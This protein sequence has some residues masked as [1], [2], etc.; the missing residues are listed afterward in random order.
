MEQNQLNIPKVNPTPKPTQIPTV[1]D[2]SISIQTPNK[3]PDEKK[4][5]FLN[6][7]SGQFKDKIRSTEVFSPSYRP[8]VKSIFIEALYSLL[9]SHHIPILMKHG[10]FMDE[11]PLISF[12][13]ITEFFLSY[14][15]KIIFFITIYFTLHYFFMPMVRKIDFPK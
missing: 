13:S 8:M 6:N 7:L 2:I 12:N 4:E 10:A 15:G 1:V 14:F 5:S 9:F 11:T 3:L